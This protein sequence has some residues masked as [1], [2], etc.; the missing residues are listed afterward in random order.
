[1]FIFLAIVALFVAVIIVK[2]KEAS[3]QTRQLSAVGIDVSKF[4]PAG[5]FISGHVDIN[6][7]VEKCW[8]FP[9]Q[10]VF[11]IYSEIRNSFKKEFLA[12]INTA[13]I[14]GIEVE[15]KTTIQSRLQLRKGM[16]LDSTP[17]VLEQ[18]NTTLERVWLVI[19][20]NDGRFEHDTIFEFSGSGA[21]V[22]ANTLRNQLFK[23]ITPVQKP[24]DIQR[25]A[26]AE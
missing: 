16:F 22:R 10:D 9:G 12:D 23:T 15:D 13:A 1:M 11:K 4:V 20:W 3:L 8:I 19:E 7:P 5:K 17:Y 18:K 25:R 21:V 6:Q 14:T 26:A 2:K 24:E